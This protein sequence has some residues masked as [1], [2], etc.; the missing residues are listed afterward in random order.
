MQE[1]LITK[2]IRLKGDTS[3]L[4]YSWLKPSIQYPEF[5][6]FENKSLEEI[7][8]S[9]GKD[10]A[11]HVYSSAALGLGDLTKPPEIGSETP[12]SETVV[13]VTMQ[14]NI[15]QADQHCFTI[16][17]IPN[18]YTSKQEE[19]IISRC[20]LSNSVVDNYPAEEIFQQEVKLFFGNALHD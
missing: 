13:T 10:T 8:K 4:G 1:T 19:Q 9:Y 2:D 14:R 6:P 18:D 11:Q 20:Y 16:K 3:Y 5:N 7:K 12:S 15:S 17:L